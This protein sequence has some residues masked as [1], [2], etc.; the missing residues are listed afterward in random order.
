MAHNLLTGWGLSRTRQVHTMPQHSIVVPCRDA[1]GTPIPASGWWEAD[2]ERGWSVSRMS[3]LPPDDDKARYVAQMFARIAP[4]YDRMNRL[5]T[6]GLDRGWRAAAVSAIAPP[7][8]ARVLDV[9]T[10]TGDF[11]ALLTP[12]VP[13]GLVVGVD[14]TV[15]MMHA[16]RWRH[17]DR[18]SQFVAGDALRLPFADARFDA[19]T[20]GFTVRNVSDIAAAFAEMARVTRPG[21]VLACLEVA[22][23]QQALVRLGHRWY[24]EI[25][26]PQLARALGADPTAYTYLPQSARR[27]PAPER[28]AELIADNGWSHVHYWR[29]GSGAAAIH[30]ARRHA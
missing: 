5:M 23:P 13:Q 2:H 28:L 8:D 4:G 25:V 15:P 24:F 17:V 20:T 6:F 30:V 3:V 12:W 7:H 9:G 11:V 1:S 22:R 27:F 19:V 26:V 18:R 16:G 29:V 14:F 21:G 10:G